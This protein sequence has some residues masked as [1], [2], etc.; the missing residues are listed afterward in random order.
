[1]SPHW[2]TVATAI[3]ASALLLLVLLA[4]FL[5]RYR[6][7]RANPYTGLRDDEKTAAFS[8]RPHRASRLPATKV[9]RFSSLEQAVDPVVASTP[10]S[11]SPTARSPSSSLHFIDLPFGTE[12]KMLVVGSSSTTKGPARAY[13]GGA[14]GSS[15]SNEMADFS[16]KSDMMVDDSNESSVLDE[17]LSLPD[18]R[19]HKR[20]SAKSE[21]ALASLVEGWSDRFREATDGEGEAGGDVT[22]W[23]VA[24]VVRWVMGMKFQQEIA[25]AFEGL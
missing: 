14:S 15:K 16:S 24:R 9:R 2:N 23:D 11:R 3:A 7:R 12:A 22:G 21:A 18:I 20:S 6:R 4:V 10:R 13:F 25:T 17:K 19:A 8:S 5:V 1:M